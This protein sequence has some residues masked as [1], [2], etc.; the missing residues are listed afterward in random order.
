M[1][2]TVRAGSAVRAA[3]WG[4]RA[5]MAA[6]FTYT[7]TL[8]FT[9]AARSVNTFEHVGAGQ[10]LRVVVGV[11]EVAAVVGLF[12]PR[13]TIPVTIGISLLMTGATVTEATLSH[14]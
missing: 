1:T 14:G 7:A 6:T 4:L 10:W 12:V 5:L 13:L 9:G 3:F 11:L 2:T 8:K